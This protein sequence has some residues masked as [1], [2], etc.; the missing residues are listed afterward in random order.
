MD[1]KEFWEH[2]KKEKEKEFKCENC[3]QYTLSYIPRLYVEGESWGE[4][5]LLVLKYCKDCFLKSNE[6]FLFDMQELWKIK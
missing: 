2:F 6:Q 1:K 3:K 5:W 4:E